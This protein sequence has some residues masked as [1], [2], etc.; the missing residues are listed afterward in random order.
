MFRFGNSCSLAP[1]GTAASVVRGESGGSSYYENALCLQHPR[2]KSECFRG[3]EVSSFSQVMEFQESFN[4]V[5]N[6]PRVAR[7]TIVV[8]A[9]RCPRG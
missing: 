4:R 5:G 7:M 2:H 3:Q 8:R 6:A 1:A 9:G